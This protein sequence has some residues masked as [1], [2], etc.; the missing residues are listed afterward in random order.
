MSASSNLADTVLRELPRIR[1]GQE[2]FYRDLHKHPELSHQEFE[3][4]RKVADRLRGRGFKVHDGIGGIGVIGVLATGLGSVCCFV[5]TWTHYPCRRPS[6][7]I[8]QHRPG[9]RRR[10]Q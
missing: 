1:D 10:W 7:W 2:G 9:N 3:T 5:R 4:A 8:T 6:D